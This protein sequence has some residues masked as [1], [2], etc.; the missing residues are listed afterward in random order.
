MHEMSVAMEIC[1]VAESHLEPGEAPRLREVGLDVGREAG[2]VVES[3]E[4]CL[5]SLL[6]TPP[7]T[8][9]EAAIRTPPGDV[10]QLTYLEVEDDDP[11]N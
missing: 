11:E 2:V 8:G 4:F 5:E 9:A 3:L 6:S 10:L 1:R 7:F